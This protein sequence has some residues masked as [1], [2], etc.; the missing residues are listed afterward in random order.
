MAE[1][2]EAAAVQAAKRR[3]QK[4]PVK[5]LRRLLIRALD[6]LIDYEAGD[7]ADEASNA[8]LKEDFRKAFNE[9]GQVRDK[10]L[11]PDSQQLG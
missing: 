3:S 1:I 7:G 9:Y 10:I 8:A 2:N 11:G 5:N 6:R 4:P